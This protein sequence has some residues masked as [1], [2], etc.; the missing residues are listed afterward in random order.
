MNVRYNLTEKRI[1]NFSTF[2]FQKGAVLMSVVKLEVVFPVCNTTECT[3]LV[4]WVCVQKVN[5]EVS[6]FWISSITA[7]LQRVNFF[8]Q[9][10][11]YFICISW[12]PFSMI[13]CCVSQTQ[14]WVLFFVVS[15]GAGLE[16]CEQYLKVNCFL[17]W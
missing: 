11:S 7:T 5:L 17:C 15:T 6:T 14:V 13:E 16:M 12:G 1:H 2:E 8:L 9:Q 3:S 10:Y 4:F